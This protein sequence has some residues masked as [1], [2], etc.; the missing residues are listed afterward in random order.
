M[1][2]NHKAFVFG[3]VFLS[4]ASSQVL[5]QAARKLGVHFYFG[6]FQT[7]AGASAPRIKL[8]LNRDGE[9]DFFDFEQCQCVQPQTEIENLRLRFEELFV[10]LLP[11]SNK[12][13]T[14]C[15][16]PP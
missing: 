11:F 9:Q 2:A 4:D 13:V 14:S 12:Q 1:Y 6:D 10:N 7:A 3:S 16:I 15:R 5:V 8:F